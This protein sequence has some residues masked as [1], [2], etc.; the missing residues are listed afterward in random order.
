[1]RIFEEESAQEKSSDG[2]RVWK[3]R[4]REEDSSAYGVNIYTNNEY[5]FKMN[6]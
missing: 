6:Y 4:E 2:G 5:A 1:M 3:W